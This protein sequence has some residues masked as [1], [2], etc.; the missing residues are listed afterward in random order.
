MWPY[1]TAKCKRG[2]YHPREIVCPESGKAEKPTLRGKLGRGLG[3]SPKQECC[4]GWWVLIV[5]TSHLN[6]HTIHGISWGHSL[7]IEAHSSTFPSSNTRSIRSTQS[8]DVE[9][10]TCPETDIISPSNS[11]PTSY[12]PAILNFFPLS[13]RQINLS[14][15]GQFCPANGSELKFSEIMTINCI[16][17]HFPCSPTDS[18]R[19]PGR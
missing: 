12:L 15:D 5:V 18:P 10:L 11:I 3:G 4:T 14:R 2:A 7:M 6:A 8:M 9:K 1:C 19:F 13:I 17:I 16:G